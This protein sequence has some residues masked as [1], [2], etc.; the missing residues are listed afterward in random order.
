VT[1]LP[2][3]LADGP[4]VLDGG[5][6]TELE[7]LGHDLS[8]DLWSAR[9]LLDD[10]DDIVRVHASF[11]AAGA[12][13]ITTASYQASVQG[14]ARAGLAP[15]RAQQ[16]I[17]R[18]VD[19]ARQAMARTGRR[20]WVAGSAGP[21]GAMLADGSEYTGAYPAGIDVQELRAFHRPQLAL[22]RDAGADVVAC[23][24]IPGVT[25]TRAV[26]D[27][28]ED[29][30]LPG[31]VS[32]TTVTGPD[33]QVRTRCGEPAADAYA[34]AAQADHVIAVG[35]N[36]TGPEGVAAAVAVAAEA[37]GKP[38]IVYPNSGEV[39]DGAARTW[40]GAPDVPG[41]PSV[42]GAETFTAGQLDEWMAAGARMIGG[43]CRVGPGAIAAIAQHL[44]A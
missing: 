37:S 26:I 34:L 19:L 1:T 9:L 10:P 12:Q 44:H 32:L 29:L 21:Y 15:D 13:V 35:V 17:R 16:L 43:C 22:L 30:A 41:D 42:P 8:S 20:A 24:T 36:C 27:E 4:L 28:L 39:W 7:Q 6:S 31:W 14:F 25:E 33:G 2:A 3:A 40:T 23:E 38:V 18:S 5:L 11:L